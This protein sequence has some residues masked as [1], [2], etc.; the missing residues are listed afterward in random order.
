MPLPTF[1]Q[2][3]SP[4]TGLA[5]FLGRL[6]DPAGE[7]SAGV[8]YG[9]GTPTGAYPAF[10]AVVAGHAGRPQPCGATSEVGQ[11]PG[12]PH[13]T[14]FT[15]SGDTTPNPPSAPV[16]RSRPGGFGL[17]HRRHHFLSGGHAL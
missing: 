11:V 17:G 8:S 12:T 6:F 15:S 13:H 3:T 9:G 10:L 7:G 16:F 14:Q 1:H 2:T 4:W 5:D